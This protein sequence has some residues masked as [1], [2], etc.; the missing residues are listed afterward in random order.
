MELTD[1]LNL[2]RQV[3][4]QAFVR[5]W[6]ATVLGGEA[7]APR[8]F[9]KNQGREFFLKIKVENFRALFCARSLNRFF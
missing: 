8:S 1:P 5:I 7:F 9:F 6:P 3:I 2:L 4:A